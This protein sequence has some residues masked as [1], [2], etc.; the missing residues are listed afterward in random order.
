MHRT[1]WAPCCHEGGTREGT[2][3]GLRSLKCAPPARHQRVTGDEAATH[4]RPSGDR[5]ATHRRRTKNQ[6]PTNLRR[7]CAPDTLPKTPR[8]P[9]SDVVGALFARKDHSRFSAKS[10]FAGQTRTRSVQ[11]FRTTWPTH[12]PGGGVRLPDRSAARGDVG[13]GVPQPTGSSTAGRPTHHPWKRS[14][15]GRRRAHGRA[16]GHTTGAHRNRPYC[17]TDHNPAIRNYAP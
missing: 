7:E 6:P 15:G 1:N 2:W 13:G 17:R 14:R 8:A 11:A 4:R 10:T 12:S 9:S 16:H 3:G 5:A